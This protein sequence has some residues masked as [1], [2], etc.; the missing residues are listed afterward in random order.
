[1]AKR[2]PFILPPLTTS[3]VSLGLTRNSIVSPLSVRRMI[4]FIPPSTIV[5]YTVLSP[6]VRVS[7]FFE[8]CSAIVL[9]LLSLQET[10]IKRI[11]N[12]IMR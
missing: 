3:A 4:E 12:E 6:V 8:D 5:P 9:G 7:A 11:N 1:M 10:A 2:S